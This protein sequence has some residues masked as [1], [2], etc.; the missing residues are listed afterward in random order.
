MTNYVRRVLAEI[1]CG[2]LFDAVEAEVGRDGH[3]PYWAV[4]LRVGKVVKCNT[5][6]RLDHQWGRPWLIPSDWTREKVQATVLTA[7]KF[8]LEHELREQFAVCD[9]ADGPSYPFYPKH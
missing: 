9:S 3:S 7:C 1:E 6:G 8:W 2:F 4:V 5:T